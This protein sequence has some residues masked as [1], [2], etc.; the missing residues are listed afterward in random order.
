MNSLSK[1]NC[2]HMKN[3]IVLT[4]L[5]V[6]SACSTSKV[7]REEDAEKIK[8][9]ENAKSA[10]L[11]TSYSAT[12]EKLDDSKNGLVKI[13][14]SQNNAVKEEWDDTYSQNTVYATQCRGWKNGKTQVF[15]TGFSANYCEL[16]TA[17]F[18]L[19]H[20]LVFGFLYD[21]GLP[22]MSYGDTVETKVQGSGSRTESNSHVTDNWTPVKSNEVTLSING[23]SSKVSL[24]D[25]VGQFDPKKFKMT[26]E[27]I[28]SDHASIEFD[29]NTLDVTDSLGEMIAKIKSGRE[30]KALVAK[31]P[32]N[33]YKMNYCSSSDVF[34]IVFTP[35]AQHPLE[36]HC[37][38]IVRG[39]LHV[40]QAVAGG[41]LVSAVMS[42]P[43]TEGRSIFI[44][45]KKR[46]VDDEPVGDILVKYT[47][48]L[49]YNT[50]LGAQRT[51]HGFEYLG[52]VKLI[53]QNNSNN[54]S[55][56]PEQD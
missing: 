5:L 13:I 45:T 29:G 14:V 34:N 44:K 1:S 8:S 56:S 10:A 4:V 48:P 33:K 25:S 40:Q 50:V 43:G 18:I 7:L 55:I 39:P 9:H 30:E 19:D 17:N 32:E 15:E 51:I 36:S 35:Y 41:I 37:L 31:L 11:P 12:F 42:Y 22:F 53:H 24:H 2:K 28:I 20:I 26:D 38:Y 49:S 52:E 54:Y 6:S 21:M 3:L 27:Y 16:N 47:G 23:V 46:Y